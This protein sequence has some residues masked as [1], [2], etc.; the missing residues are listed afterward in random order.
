LVLQVL[1]GKERRDE[2]KTKE[3]AEP[4]SE[5]NSASAD[6]ALKPMFATGEQA[7]VLTG[8]PPHQ[9]Y[10]YR[11][12]GGGPPFVQHGVRVR[13]PIDGLRTWAAGLPRFTSRAEAYA[14]D[15]H[16]ADG[17]AKQRAATAR[18]R[19]RRWDDEPKPARKK[20]QPKGA[21]AA[22]GERAP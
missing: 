18:A 4:V 20:R 1:D 17:A 5:P 19:K 9:L 7:A 3:Q 15:P 21:S 22:A 8:L 10:L 6:D 16:R 11:R 12:R 2:L 14:H 13:Y